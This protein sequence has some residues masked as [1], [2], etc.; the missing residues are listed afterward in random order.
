LVGYSYEKKIESFEDL[1][2]YRLAEGF[3]SFHFAEKKQFVRISRASL[4]ETR[5]WLLRGIQ[6]RFIKRKR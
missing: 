3:G 4:Y 5:H 1:D 2:V 6:E